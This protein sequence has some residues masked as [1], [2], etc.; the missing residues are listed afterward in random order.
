LR[1]FEDQCREVLDG[2]RI[3]RQCVTGI[4]SAYHELPYVL[5]GPDQEGGC[6]EIT[7]RI[8][9][10]PRLLITPRQILE[11]FGEIFTDDGFMDQ[12][13][14]MRSFRFAAARDPSKQIKSDELFVQRHDG[15]FQVRLDTRQDELARAEDVRTSL[16]HC[17]NPRLYPI[18]LEHFIQSILHR[19]FH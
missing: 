6:T 11:K 10:S 9:V 2:T 17:P 8:K 19:E 4:I 16:I 13:L 5:I 12:E 1:D 7:G 18:S 3:V 15:D 14:Q